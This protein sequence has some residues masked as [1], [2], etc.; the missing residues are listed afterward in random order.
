MV[1]RFSEIKSGGRSILLHDEPKIFNDSC[2]F[3]TVVK[4]SN[5]PKNV[6]WLAVEFVFQRSDESF[7]LSGLIGRS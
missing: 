3:A 1:D 6:F 7:P 4:I 5:M 2:F